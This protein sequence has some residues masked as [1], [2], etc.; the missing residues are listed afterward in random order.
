[1]RDR[2]VVADDRRRVVPHVHHHVVLQVA[3]GADLH[4][5]RLGPHHC[6]RPEACAL[7]DVDMA[8][9]A[10]RRVDVGRLREGRRCV[11][12]GACHEVRRLER[13]EKVLAQVAGLDRRPRPAPRRVP[14]NSFFPGKPQHDRPLRRPQPLGSDRQGKV[15]LDGGRGEARLGPHLELLLQHEADDATPR[16]RASHRAADPRRVEG[17]Q[18]RSGGRPRDGRRAARHRRRR[19]EPRAGNA[20]RGL[21]R[22]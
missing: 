17:R 22:P 9:H 8:E 4:A 21:L 11:G 13:V 15:V 7:A 5:L 16:G 1:M 6:I 14:A 20:G 3:I 19:A 18:G 2:A 10:R 12:I